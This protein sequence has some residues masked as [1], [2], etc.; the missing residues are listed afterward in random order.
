MSVLLE[1][2]ER[3]TLCN[4]FLYVL[5]V[6]LESIDLL[7]AHYAGIFDGGPNALKDPALC[8]N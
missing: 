2:I 8:L 1:C 6:L 4:V 3:L 7:L 5:V